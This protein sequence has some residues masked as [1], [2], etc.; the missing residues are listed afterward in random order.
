MR[1]DEKRRY[2]WYLSMLLRFREMENDGIHLFMEDDPTDPETVAK[3]I[4][5]NESSEFLQ[6]YSE[7]PLNGMKKMRFSRKTRN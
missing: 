7:D 2:T 5:L 1:E 4:M 6:E 3:T